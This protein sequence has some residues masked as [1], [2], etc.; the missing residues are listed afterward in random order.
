M[1][2]YDNNL[3]TPRALSDFQDL[4]KEVEALMSEATGE[5]FYLLGK[6]DKE[7]K[8]ALELFCLFTQKHMHRYEMRAKEQA[9][10]DYLGIEKSEIRQA[11]TSGKES[12]V[13]DNGFASM[14]N[15][16]A[17]SGMRMNT[18]GW[19]QSKELKLN[20]INRQIDLLI[21]RKK[22]I[23]KKQPKTFA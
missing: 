2:N 5:R 9:L 3:L 23:L 1:I 16:L 13:S 15:M 17:D 18:E 12:L 4:E 14:Y 19:L 8:T 22:E 6:I 21:D 7:H 10:S 11:V 20:F